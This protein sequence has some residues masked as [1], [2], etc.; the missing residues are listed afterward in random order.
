MKS[1]KIQQQQMLERVFNWG[2]THIEL[3]PDSSS[4]PEVITALGSATE[5]LKTLSSQQVWGHGLLQQSGNSHAEARKAVKSKLERITHTA[6][7]LNLDQFYT[8]KQKTD[9]AL[10]AAALAFA[11]QVQPFK[12]DFIKRGLPLD[13]VES[14]TAAVE[15][16]QRSA[17][18]QNSSKGAQSSSIAEFNKTLAKALVDLKQFD[19]IVKNTL[20]DNAGVMASWKIARKIARPGT[21]AAAAPAAPPAETAMAKTAGA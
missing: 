14:L 7:V 4:A 9:K 8:P 21:K 13:F 12:K 1:D 10:I 17:L 18:Q 11:E 3:F 19:A 15:D 2:Q 5:K 16:L 6:R 20:S